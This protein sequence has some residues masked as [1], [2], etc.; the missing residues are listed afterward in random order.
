MKVE[1]LLTLLM[2]L[3]ERKNI[4]ATEL[5]E[6]L[7]VSKRTIYRDVDSLANAGIP[8]YTTTGPN[9][10]I[11]IMEEYK[12]RKQL[13]TKNDLIS[14]VTSLTTMEPTL[15]EQ[16]FKYALA[17]LQSLVSKEIYEEV[18]RQ[19]EAVVV[20]LAGWKPDTR[21]NGY[22]TLFKEAM[23]NHQLVTFDYFSGKQQ[24]TT[25]EI[26]PYRLLHKGSS[27]YIQGY[28]LL[29]KEV[30]TFRFSRIEKLS[31]LPT[32]FVPRDFSVE[33]FEQTLEK[34]YPLVEVTIK[35]PENHKRE[36]IGLWGDQ[37]IEHRKNGEY[38]AKVLIL[39][40]VQGYQTLLA[41]GAS[42]EVT[43]PKRVRKYLT[44]TIASLTKIYKPE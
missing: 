28:C 42:C 35:F 44:D 17:K 30:R 1:R 20:D 39:D 36:I 26:E 9:G 10:G 15:P 25:R 40:T 22:L 19:S 33:N 27:W 21:E 6:I 16:T 23:A 11:H 2:L 38:T 14:L 32:T 34:D 4:K 41:M 3:L 13:F 8:I 43:A 5:A 18:K 7:A 37:V 29:R 12:V 31:S 24:A